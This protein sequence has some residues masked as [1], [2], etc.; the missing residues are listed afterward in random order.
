M[1]RDV[2]GL[3]AFGYRPER[4]RPID[5]FPQTHHVE[6]LAELRLSTA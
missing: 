6:I 3:A 1:A 4:V 2:G 5:L